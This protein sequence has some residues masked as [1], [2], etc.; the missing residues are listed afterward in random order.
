MTK[1]TILKVAVT[2]TIR[3]SLTYIGLFALLGMASGFS[4]GQ[5]RSSVT[6]ELVWSFPESEIASPQFSADGNFIVLVSRIHWPD[7]DEAE[8]LPES[9]FD[10]LEARKRQDPRFADPI[11]RLINLKG[12][13]V[14]EV[15]YGTN[16]AIAEDNKSIAFSR[17]RKPIT[18]MR[19]LA[20]TQVG[21]DIQVFNCEKKE[22]RT[23]AEPPIGYFDNPILLPDGHSIAYTVNEAVNG[24]MG[25]SVG[26]ERVDTNGGQKESILAKEI[27]PAVPCP[28][29]EPG[30]ATS[31]QITMCSQETKRSLSFPT[32][33]LK[34]EMA[35]D[36]LLALQAEP[37]P[38][39][40]D[41]Y[42]ASHYALNLL[43]VFPKMA[44]V[45][46]MGQGDMHA[47]WDSSFQPIA[48][49]KVMIFAGHWKGWLPEMAPRNANRRSIYSPNGMYYIAVEPV[50][51][52]PSQFT[53]Y[54]AADGHRLFT[55][56]RLAGVYDLAWSK[57]SRRFAV[58]AQS[59]GV[60]V[61]AY[62]ENLYV[63]SVR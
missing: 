26:I 9:F 40:G 53:L 6:R 48:E 14:C 7:G 35:G 17:Q 52:E 56:S 18:G 62:R 23:I 8:G 25:G 61:S 46:S 42:L 33:T 47:V 59:K 24:A 28:P 55:S 43:A 4:S 3:T 36:Q 54:R 39:V 19:T 49:S 38:S 22:A 45:F 2:V 32:L 50:K 34:V 30:K 13:Q 16:P 29:A 21:N 60:P 15:R 57:D 12:S 58:V 11:I 10:K 51:E 1:R 44:R 27:T 37:I 5:A 31:F 20:E 63:Y 41:M